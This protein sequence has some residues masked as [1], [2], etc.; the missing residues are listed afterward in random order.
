VDH[1]TVIV[2]AVIARAL[3]ARWSSRGEKSD[4]RGS[5]EG[6]DQRYVYILLLFG[7]SVSGSYVYGVCWSTGSVG[8]SRLC[9]DEPSLAQIGIGFLER[10][11]NVILSDADAV[12]VVPVLYKG[13]AV[14]P[15]QKDAILD[16]P[17][18]SNCIVPTRLIRCL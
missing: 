14:L 5:G 10:V 6:R 3:L 15:P 18:S 11:K 13:L 16:I 7:R 12:I 8:S 2:R 1:Y 17:A 4:N 9:W